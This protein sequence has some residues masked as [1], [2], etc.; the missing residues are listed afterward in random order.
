MRW[1]RSR[2]RPA[3]RRW[4]IDRGKPLDRVY[5]EH[6]LSEHK[7]DLRGKVLEI[8]GR[9]YTEN[10]GSNVTQL[11][12]YDVVEGA[13]IDIVG[14]LATGKGLEENSYDCLLILQTLMMIH[15]IKGATEQ[16]FRALKPGGVALATVN[17]LAPNCEDPCHDMWQWNLTPNAARLLF[18]N[19]FG[20]ENVEVMPYGNYAVASSFIAGLSAQDVNLDY[21]S[22]EPGYEVLTGIRAVK[23]DQPTS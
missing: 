5:L 21:W 12:T 14:D 16:I 19:Q 9:Y 15:D 4:G 1:Y 10:F 23:T 6:F 18:G 11:I 13:D 22:Y 7:A 2:L 20:Q 8:G 3:S 17:F